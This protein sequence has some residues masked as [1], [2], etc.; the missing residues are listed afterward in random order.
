MA[1][2]GSCPG[3]PPL[4]GRARVP[5]G[6]RHE[7]FLGVPPPQAVEILM[8]VF[9]IN[10]AAELL[11]RDRRTLVRA[12]RNVKPD[13]HEGKNPRW[14]L[15]SFIDALV[16]GNGHHVEGESQR[17]NLDALYAQFDAAF[18]ELRAEP[19]LAQRRTMALKLAPQIRQ[20]DRM[21]RE[22]SAADGEPELLT[23]LR[24]DK[25]TCCFCAVSRNHVSGR[26]MILGSILPDPNESARSKPG[27][28]NMT[29]SRSSSVHRTGAMWHQPPSTDPTTRPIG[30]RPTTS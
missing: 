27:W 9:S 2:P 16:R 26:G 4:A 10:A 15:R 6:A 25:S 24:A 28:I 14:R 19:S 22:V 13:A 5:G 8:K 1:P 7:N 11:E 29:Q 17:T 18:G 23:Q 30:T 12:M 21:K 20:M 3:R